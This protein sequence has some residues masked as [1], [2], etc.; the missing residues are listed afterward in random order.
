[1]TSIEEKS[2]A[3]RR[4]AEGTF[5]CV[6]A[7]GCGAIHLTIGFVTIRL[8]PGAFREFATM[9]SEAAAHVKRTEESYIH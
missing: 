2:C 8:E 7:C 4:L 5:F 6:D 9:A 1:M 3:K